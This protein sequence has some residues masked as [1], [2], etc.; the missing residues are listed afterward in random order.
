MLS[1]KR[2]SDQ[3]T[4]KRIRYKNMNVIRATMDR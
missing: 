3:Y 4:P 2:I 1:G